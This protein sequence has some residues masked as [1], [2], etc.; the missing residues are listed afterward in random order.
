MIYTV[1]QFNIIV[2]YN[3]FL[4]TVGFNYSSL[5][6]FCPLRPLSLAYRSILISH[7]S[8]PMHLI[9][10]EVTLIY[11]S[12]P[13]IHSSLSMPYSIS[14][15]PIIECAINIIT[16]PLAMFEPFSIGLSIIPSSS[17]LVLSEHINRNPI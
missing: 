13:H 1:P 3:L 14:P 17:F 6:K 2:K 15:V 12:I 4:F 8:K 16:L 11:G 5:S 9:I 10:Y 7:L